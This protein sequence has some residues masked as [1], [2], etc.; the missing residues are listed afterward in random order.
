MATRDVMGGLVVCGHSATIWPRSAPKL[1]T[2]MADVV[3][4]IA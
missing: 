1:F 4:C 2:A 3:E